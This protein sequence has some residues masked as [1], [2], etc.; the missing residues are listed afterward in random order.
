[1]KHY[2]FDWSIVQDSGA[3]LENCV[4]V[5]LLK[6]VQY[7][8]DALGLELELHHFRDQEQREVG[9]IITERRKPVVAI[10]VKLSDR[11]PTRS[12]RYFKNKF[13]QV[14]AIQLYLS[15]DRSKEA[16]QSA[17]EYQTKEGI[18]VVPCMTYLNSLV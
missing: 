7:Q 15:S 2:H 18:R 12:L 6:W 9:F 1:M 11:G 3:R 16:S 17:R 8:R 10:E 4:A 14:E 5:H 13:P